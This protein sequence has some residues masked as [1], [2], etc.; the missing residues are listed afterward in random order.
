MYKLYNIYYIYTVPHNNI[1]LSISFAV[2]GFNNLP[3]RGY[4]IFY[5]LK[6]HPLN[7]TVIIF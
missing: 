4:F 2:T 5:I 1:A 6:I 7:S 3:E